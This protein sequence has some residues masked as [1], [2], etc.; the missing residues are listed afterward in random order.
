[1]VACY[2][3]KIDRQLPRLN[4]QV[5]WWKEYLHTVQLQVHKELN[6]W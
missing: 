2:E 6:N 4:K 1:M 3:N 5:R